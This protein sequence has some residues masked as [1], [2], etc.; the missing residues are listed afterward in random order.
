[1][2]ALCISQLS[3]VRARAAPKVYAYARWCSLS[4][5]TWFNLFMRPSNA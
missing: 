2:K 1:M 5:F 4:Q 3:G